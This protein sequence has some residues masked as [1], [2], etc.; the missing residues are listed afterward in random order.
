LLEPELSRVAKWAANG[1]TAYDAAH[2]AV[3]EQCA[4][5]RITDD[6]PIVAGAPKLATALGGLQ[7][8]PAPWSEPVTGPVRRASH[9]GASRA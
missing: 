9:G 3:A 7:V 8:P 4:V 2:V 6:D 1:L 5:Q